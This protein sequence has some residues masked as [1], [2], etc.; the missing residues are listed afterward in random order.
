MQRVPPLRR[1]KGQRLGAR[2]GVAARLGGRIGA[3][4]AGACDRRAGL[5]GARHRLQR[6]D[7]V[8]LH[9]QRLDRGVQQRAVHVEPVLDRAQVGDPLFE[10]LRIERRHQHRRHAHGKWRLS[11]EQRFGARRRSRCR[12]A[13][14]AGHPLQRLVHVVR[15]RFRKRHSSQGIRIGHWIEPPAFGSTVE[16]PGILFSLSCPRCP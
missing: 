15:E 4:I 1:V 16:D 14:H 5:R 7:R 6:D 8:A 11:P 2:R 10:L 12:V 9:L 3:D 13:P